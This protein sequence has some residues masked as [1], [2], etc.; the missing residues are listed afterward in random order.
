[1]AHIINFFS[2]YVSMTKPLVKSEDDDIYFEGK[3]K[4]NLNSTLSL[5]KSLR[6]NDSENVAATPFDRMLKEAFAHA[7]QNEIL[8]NIKRI[9]HRQK[10]KRQVYMYTKAVA[11][12]ILVVIYIRILPQLSKY[13]YCPSSSAPGWMAHGG[14]VY[15]NKLK[16]AYSLNLPLRVNISDESKDGICFVGAKHQHFFAQISEKVILIFGH[17]AITLRRI[18]GEKGILLITELFTFRHSK[19]RLPKINTDDQRL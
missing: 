12:V 11:S 9:R 5:A 15:D 3:T 18:S 4:D 6:L 1:M 7:D 17:C 19:Y 14:Y 8:E 2:L 10:I 13:N 16:E